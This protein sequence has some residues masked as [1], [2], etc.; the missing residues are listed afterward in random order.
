MPAPTAPP[1][2]SMRCSSFELGFRWSCFVPF[3]LCRVV[4]L[5][6]RPLCL[7]PLLQFLVDHPN[8]EQNP[9]PLDLFLD[10]FKLRRRTSSGL[11]A[12]SSSTRS[13][14]SKTLASPASPSRSAVCR[15]SR[16]S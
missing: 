11:C 15:Y 7:L 3:L 8:F 6:R 10:R 5:R 13:S 4:L 16:F 12:T 14:S 1:L 2:R 9:A